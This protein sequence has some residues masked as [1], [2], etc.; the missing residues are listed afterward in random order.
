MLRPKP[1]AGNAY[2]RRLINEARA[3]G[4]DCERTGKRHLCFVKGP[5]KVVAP[6]TPRDGDRSIK[7]TLS[8]LRRLDSLSNVEACAVSA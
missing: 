3:L 2:G 6:G 5:F 1:R 7:K 4:W 8:R